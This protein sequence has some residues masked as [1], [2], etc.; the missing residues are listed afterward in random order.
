MN[1]NTAL[2]PITEGAIQGRAQP[3][4]N[5]RDLHA[6]L[7]VRA[8]FAHWIKRRIQLHGFVEG[9][10]FSIF[11]LPNLANQN[12]R[13]GDRRS[14][15]YHL[16]IEA[17]K[18]IAMA[19]H[20]EKG[21]EARDYFI[22]CERIAHQ[23]PPSA[24]EVPAID[25][26]LVYSQPLCLLIQPQAD[27]TCVMP[28]GRLQ[29]FGWQDRNAHHHLVIGT[30]WALDHILQGQA[31]IPHYTLFGTP[32]WFDLLGRRALMAVGEAHTPTRK[33]LQP[34]PAAK[35]LIIAREFETHTLYEDMG[36]SVAR[37]LV[38]REPDCG[39]Y[40]LF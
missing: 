10:D 27:I 11:D 14:V 18:H 17:A 39:T 7:G 16:T 33:D 28:D 15:E 37:Y 20:T 8:Y 24:E 2:I 30:P 36:Y 35:S 6:F 22:E 26:G 25:Q 4:C 32:L 19:E 3:L 9:E 38:P 12:E 31:P 13:G 29:T 21:K 40:K 5:A 1:T 34:L 23:L